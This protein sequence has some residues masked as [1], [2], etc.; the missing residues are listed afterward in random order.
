MKLNKLS[1]AALATTLALGGLAM[2][3]ASHAEVSSSASIASMY[4][5]RGQDISA[6]APVV[7]GD[8]SYSHESGAY[9][10]LWISSIGSI[11]TPAGTYSTESDWTIGFS[12]EAGGMGYDIGYYKFWYPEL[13]DSFSDADA[14]YYLG[15]TYGD[16]GFKAY[17]DGKDTHDYNY[18]TL[19]YGMGAF[20][21][22][23]G[24]KDVDGADGDY[25]HVGLSYAATD[26]LSFTASKVVDYDTA[27]PTPDDLLFMISYSLP[28]DLK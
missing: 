24:Y 28:I 21:A 23:V 6:S 5:W 19:S 11:D 26:S 22:L 8:I 18:Y 3:V 13:G 17:I 7:S 1:S 2:P 12:G 15:L 27:A 16:F 14:E 9:A 25:T 4:L 10:S 20:S